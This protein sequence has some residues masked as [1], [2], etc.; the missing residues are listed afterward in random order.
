MKAEVTRAKSM[1][2]YDIKAK[3]MGTMS[4]FLASKNFDLRYRMP[5]PPPKEEPKVTA[6][7]K[8]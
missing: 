2:G 6:A 8:T 5:T 4:S 1:V 7:S 3:H